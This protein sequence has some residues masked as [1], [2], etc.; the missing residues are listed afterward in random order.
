MNKKSYIIRQC[1]WAI[2]SALFISFAIRFTIEKNGLIEFVILMWIAAVMPIAVFC[3][4]MWE[5]RELKKYDEKKKQ[6]PKPKKIKY[7]ING[8]GRL[9][10]KCPYCITLPD[11]PF[12]VYV[13]SSYC[14]KCQYFVSD[15]IRNEIVECNYENE[16]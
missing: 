9:I 5:H 8:K 3:I 4:N 14:E 15:D 16:K 12:K 11:I 6:A 2:W 10:T 13:G 7:H 1:F